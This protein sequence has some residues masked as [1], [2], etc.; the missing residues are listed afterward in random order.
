MQ[1]KTSPFVAVLALTFGA[2]ALACSSDSDD[3]GNIGGTGGASAGSGGS[4]GTGGR[5]GTGTGGG[6]GGTTASGGS[7][8]S[9]RRVECQRRLKSVGRKRG[10]LRG[11]GRRRQ[12][13][14]IRR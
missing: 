13:S 9:Y 10:K 5:G 11:W 8:K 4:S 6:S 3:G 7:G 14:W 1:L 12:R 2:A